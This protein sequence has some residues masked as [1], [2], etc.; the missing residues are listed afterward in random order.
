M[1]NNWIYIRPELDPPFAFAVT[2]AGGS[3]HWNV[4]AHASF[5][6]IAWDTKEEFDLTFARC[7]TIPY[8][9]ESVNEENANRIYTIFENLAVTA[10]DTLTFTWTPPRRRPDHY[11]IYYQTT[12]TFDPSLPAT[13]ILPSSGLVDGNI[14][15]YATSCA[16]AWETAITCMFQIDCS[17]N[18]TTET[19][20]IRGNRT[21]CLYA[22][23]QI[24]PYPA[25]GAPQTL[26]SAY[27]VLTVAQGER[28]Q[29]TV[30]AATAGTTSIR[31]QS[32]HVSIL[33]VDTNDQHPSY[34]QILFFY[35]DAHHDLTEN[36]NLDILGLSYKKSTISGLQFGTLRITNPIGPGLMGFMGANQAGANTYED[37]DYAC[38]YLQKWRDAGLPVEVYI[39]GGTPDSRYVGYW[40]GVITDAPHWATQD[41]QDDNEISVSIKINHTQCMDIDLGY[42]GIV[43]KDAGANTIS[44]NGDHTALLV[45]GAKIRTVGSTA[46][47]AI[48]AVA[49]STYTG[50]NTVITV[51]GDI[52]D[53][54]GDGRV[55]LW[56]RR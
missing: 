51:T 11:C 1:A 44:I 41:A 55:E 56:L 36:T 12:S 17:T 15:G 8:D 2:R 48:W 16:I 39:A 19:Y 14:P 32:G 50:G 18:T 47:N 5:L 9:K 40:Y 23:A 27:P 3:G 25:G 10:D 45:S 13:K 38:Y 52:T 6:L 43:A 20:L 49:F 37:Q 35:P 33:A 22:G 21:A 24:V 28:T 26:T 46:D 53:A 30:A 7:F 29:L 42:W 34:P 4:H 31:F 54:T